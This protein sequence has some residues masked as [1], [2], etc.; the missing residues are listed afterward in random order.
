[1][2]L[3]LIEGKRTRKEQ[4][5]EGH[6]LHFGH[7]RCSP[8]AHSGSLARKSIGEDLTGS[9][10]PSIIKKAF[11]MSSGREDGE[12]YKSTGKKERT[13][14]E[15]DIK[16][17]IVTGSSKRCTSVHPARCKRQMLHLPATVFLISNRQ[18]KYPR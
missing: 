9:I 12:G 1:M 8:L 13:E 7:Q 2:A 4:N 11:A 15:A 18:E 10:D 6:H 5:S 16:V 17:N 3:F 14:R